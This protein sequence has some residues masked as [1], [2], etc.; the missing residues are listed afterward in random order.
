[1]GKRHADLL[2]RFD[3]TLLA[4]RLA[5]RN[6]GAQTYFAVVS[7]VV[8]STDFFPRFALQLFN[9]RGFGSRQSKAVDSLPW[10]FCR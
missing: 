4:S 7:F 3:S 10:C 1:M 6:H 2:Q 5:S 9:R 8:L